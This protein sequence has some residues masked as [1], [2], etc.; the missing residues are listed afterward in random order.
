MEVGPVKPIPVAVIVIV[1]AAVRVAVRVTAEAKEATVH[2]NNSALMSLMNQLNKSH[3]KL[4][5]LLKLKRVNIFQTK[6][7]V[8]AVAVIKVI[9]AEVKATVAVVVAKV[10]VAAAAKVT[11]IAAAK[12]T[13]KAIVASQDHQARASHIHIKL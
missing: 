9:A 1:R 4:S 7:T 11:A 8:I 5:Q 2:T 13:V 6:V 10:T 12:D 3:T